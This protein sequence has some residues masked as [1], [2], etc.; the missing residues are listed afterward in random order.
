MQPSPLTLEDSLSAPKRDTI[1]VSTHSLVP[2]LS[3]IPLPSLTYFLSLNL[4]TLGFSKTGNHTIWPSF[5]LVHNVFKAHLCYSCFSTSSVFTVE[6]F[7]VFIPHTLS[8]HLS[9]AGNLGCSHILAIMNN[10]AMHTP[11]QILVWTLVFQFSQVRYTGLKLLSH[12]VTLCTAFWKPTTIFHNSFSILHSPQQL[13]GFWLLHIPS[14]TAISFKKKIITIPG[15]VKWYLTMVLICIFQKINDLKHF[16]IV[17]LYIFSGEMSIQ[18]LCPVFKL[19]CLFILKLFVYRTLW[20]PLNCILPGKTTEVVCHF[21][22]R[23]SSQPRDWT[24][25]SCVSCLSRQILYPLSNQRS[26]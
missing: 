13:W 17:H 20:D 2:S 26:L 3:P 1:P 21:L 9:V 5:G 25:I 4:P 23:G 11:M 24:H 15:I 6:Y 14:N 10:T 19:G 18:I 8:I 16:L 7:T 12:M 22:S